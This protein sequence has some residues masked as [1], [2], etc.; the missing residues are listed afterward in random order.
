MHSLKKK[1]DEWYMTKA[2]NLAQK[3]A[4]LGEVPVGAVVVDKNGLVIGRGYNMVECRKSQQEHAEM[5]ALRQAYRKMQDWRLDGACVYVTLEPCKMCLYAIALSRCSAI[6]YGA[7]SPLFGASYDPEKEVPM[8]IKHL[9]SVKGGVLEKK[10][11]DLLKFFFK[12]KRGVYE[13]FKNTNQTK[14]ARAKKRDRA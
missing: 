12:Q 10:S 3:A 9:K 7:Q 13:D 8:Y 5:R 11:A 14:I 4:L 1:S 6:V 2:L